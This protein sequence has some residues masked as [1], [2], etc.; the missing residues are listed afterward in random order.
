MKKL[1]ESINRAM[2]RYLRGHG[3]VTFYLEPVSRECK[4]VCWLHLYNQEIKDE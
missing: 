3:W 4:G 2:A 1:I